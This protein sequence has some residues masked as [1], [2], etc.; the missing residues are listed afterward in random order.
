LFSST[1][2]RARARRLGGRGRLIASHLGQGIYD[3]E[4]EGEGEG[5]MRDETISP[6]PARFV[7]LPPYLGVVAYPSRAV[8]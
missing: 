1:F 4:E 8:M 5:G 3:D 6:S 2:F 7:H